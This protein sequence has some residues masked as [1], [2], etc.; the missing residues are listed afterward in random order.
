VF[1][2][3]LTAAVLPAALLAVLVG[4]RPPASPPETAPPDETPD[5]PPWFEDVT[6]KLGVNFTHDPGPI[7]KYPMYQAIGSG[8][9]IHDLDGD[10]RPDLL[11]LTNGG[12]NAT[13][14]NKLYRQKPDGTFE[15]VSAGSGLDFPGHN[16]GVA[17]GDVNND[18]KPDILITQYTGARLF[19]NLGGMKFADVTEEA[20]I[21]NPSWGASAAFVDY[22]RDGW[23]DLVIVNYVNYD[24]NWPCLSRAGGE[25]YCAPVSFSGT[26]TRLFRNLG[27]QLKG[28]PARAKFEDVTAA[29][30]LGSVAGPGLGVVCADFDGDGWPDIF[31]ANDGK[32]NHLW[33]NQKDGT[34]KEE[35]ASRGAAYNQMGLSYAGMGI[36]LG[37]VDNDGLLDLYVTHLTSETNTLWRQGPRG[38]FKDVS[39]AWGLTGTRWRGTGFGTLMADFDHD[40]WLDIAIV[41]GRVERAGQA[42]RPGLSPH[43]APYGERNQLLA[44]AGDGRF[45]DVSVNSPA[46]CGYYTVARG[47]ACGDIDGDGAPDLLVTAIGEKARVLRNVAANRGHWLTVRAIDPALNRDAYGAE[48]AVRAGGVRRVRVVNPAESFLSASSGVAHFGL[49]AAAAVDGFDVTWPDGTKETFPGVAADR[50]VELRKGSGTK[51]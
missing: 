14:T 41:N 8:C 12:P 9:A 21:K 4:C 39:A 34:F 11:L 26:A 7:T 48:V 22:D 35:G 46:L 31:V 51:P 6:D 15:D 32:P 44:N 49:G 19:L 16:M 18:G 10:G 20:G 23:L 50:A 17:I 24:P 38:L 33:I 40:G 13:S 28:G 42:P 30:R 47:L 2:R 45:K 5:G 29:S 37:D 1:V 43:W 36:A 27:G 3:H 25:D